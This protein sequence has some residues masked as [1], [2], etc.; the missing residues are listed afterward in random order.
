MIDDLTDDQLVCRHGPEAPS[1][2]FHLWHLARYADSLPAKIGAAGGGLWEKEELPS[3]WGFAQASL[4]VEK[5]GTGMA[6]GESNEPPWPPK[7]VL[8]DYA[9]RAFAVADAVVGAVDEDWF[10]RTSQQ[11]DRTVGA[12]IMISLTHD[13]RHLG[14]I[15]AIRG[16]IGVTGT[17][18]I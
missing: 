6:G 15:E 17:A 1:I 7:L 4:G 12:V 13:S 8:L 14:M 9:R 10:T 11:P 3:R 5:S 18:T 2:A 16:V